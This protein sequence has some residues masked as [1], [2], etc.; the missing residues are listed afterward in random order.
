VHQSYGFLIV[1]RAF[2]FTVT[3]LAL[4]LASPLLLLIAVMVK[5][6]SPTGPVFY[7]W[8]V[9]GKNRKPFM[10]YKFR[11]MVP[12]ADDLKESLK[13]Y[14]EMNGAV[15]KMR[16]D[17]RITPFGRFLRKFSLDELPQ[18]YSVLKGDMSLVGPR[19]PS[20]SES[21]HFEYWQHRKICVKPGIT[22]LWQVGGRSNITDFSEW[23]RMDLEYI[24]TASFSTDLKV[25]LRTIPVVLRGTGAY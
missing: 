19:P 10:G 16:N 21:D 6:T 25:L 18:L 8:A 17:P 5:V 15:F 9:L 1:K 24:R 11:T 7:P 14:N 3:A 23:V 12:N 22:C 20:K 4:L 2:D 13:Q